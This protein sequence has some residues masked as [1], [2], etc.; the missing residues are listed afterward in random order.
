MNH[1]KYV[2]NLIVACFSVFLIPFSYSQF[3][4]CLNDKVYEAFEDHNPDYEESLLQIRQEYSSNHYVKKSKAI[5]VQLVF[6]ILYNNDQQ[7]ISDKEIQELLINLN[8]DFSETNSNKDSLRSIFQDVVGN[9]NIEF[10]LATIDPNGLEVSGINRVLTQKESFIAQDTLILAFQ[11]CGVSETNQALTEEQSE[12]LDNKL[13]DLD[14]IQLVNEIKSDKTGGSDPWDVTKYIN[15]W[16]GNTSVDLGTGPRPIVEGFAFLPNIDSIIPQDIYEKYDGIFLNY[17]TIKSS[18]T[19]QDLRVLT[20]EMGH[21]LGLRHVWGLF[22]G[23]NDDD[24]VDD[25]PLTEKSSLDQAL[26]RGLGLFPDCSALYDFDSCLS[27][28]LPDMIENYMDYSPGYCQTHFTKGQINV[29][30]NVL[31]DF[32]S[33]LNIEQSTS[34]NSYTVQELTLHPN[35]V[36]SDLFIS[37][38]QNSLLSFHSQ[39]VLIYSSLGKIYPVIIENGKIQTDNLHEGLYFIHLIINKKQYIGKFIKI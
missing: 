19:F 38:E 18:D 30:R 6:H 25:T 14:F 11:N 20:H 2:C 21:Y 13:S 17:Q 36:T 15:V 3:Q 1:H 12:C 33:G 35:P 10:E 5:T 29:M 4:S 8:Q 9:P 34:V 27:F 23:C 28:E 24:G 32:R 37:Y 39:K 26:D 7:N 16:I 31:E 22:G